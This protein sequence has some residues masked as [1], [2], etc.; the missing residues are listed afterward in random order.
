MFRAAGRASIR[1]DHGDALDLPAIDVRGGWPL[2]W[3]P[4][5]QL[6]REAGLI[7]KTKHPPDPAMTL[8]NMREMGETML[9]YYA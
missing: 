1:R 3:N 8:G 2:G 5:C 4:A 9:T 7:A 6:P